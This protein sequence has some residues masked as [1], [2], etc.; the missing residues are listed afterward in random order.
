MKIRRLP[1]GNFYAE[2][3]KYSI[4]TKTLEEMRKKLIKDGFTVYDG[5]Y[6]VGDINEENEKVLEDDDEGN[7]WYNE[8]MKKFS[9]PEIWSPN[10]VLKA[11]KSALNKNIFDH[12]VTAQNYKKEI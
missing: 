4:E 2:N 12:L 9:D 11:S 1:S 10:E 6:M 7:N 3:G 8:K 5:V